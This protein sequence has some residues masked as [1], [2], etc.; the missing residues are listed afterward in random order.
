MLLGMKGPVERDGKIF[1][2]LMPSWRFDLTDSQIADV[3]NDMR[4]R[5]CAG[6]P[7]IPTGLVSS[8]R[9][10]TVSAPLFPAAHEVERWYEETVPPSTR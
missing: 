9:A 3:L 7:L 5:W 1:N 8:V 6:A 4:Q 10:E 2:G